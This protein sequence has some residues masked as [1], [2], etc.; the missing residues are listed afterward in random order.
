MTTPYDERP[1]F[2]RLLSSLFDRGGVH[3]ARFP[4]R[5]PS[6]LPGIWFDASIEVA[7]Q[8]RAT[9]AGDAE[10]AKR[11]VCA[12]AADVTAPMSVLDLTT[13]QFQ[14]NAQ[15]AQPL[16]VPGTSVLVVNASAALSVDPEARRAAEEHDRYRAQTEHWR[17]LRDTVFADPVM[18]C[19]WWLDGHPE[20]LEKLPNMD[21]A[22]ERLAA[23]TT[24]GAGRG[25]DLMHVANLLHQFLAGLEAVDRQRLIDSVGYIMTNF[26]RPD[27]ADQLRAS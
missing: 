25:D 18:A 7:W 5:L 16:P 27:L 14:L 26:G 8:H 23:L 3:H 17:L 10:A 11:H 21:A 19:V 1:G 2:L 20:R 22:F 6:N 4:T 9:G 24:S 12:R 13:A 15:L